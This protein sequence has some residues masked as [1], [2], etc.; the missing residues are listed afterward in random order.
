MINTRVSINCDYDQDSK[1]I[2]KK[3]QNSKL[4]QAN[5]SPC[6]Y[7]ISPHQ[8]V[9]FQIPTQN[10]QEIESSSS[11]DSF[12]SDYEK[13]ELDNQS[14]VTFGE[15]SSSKNYL[16]YGLHKNLNS[17]PASPSDISHEFLPLKYKNDENY[18]IKLFKFLRKPQN[19]NCKTDSCKFAQYFNF[20]RYCNGNLT[21]FDNKYNLVKSKKIISCKKIY[22]SQHPF[23]DTS[24]KEN[25][26][27]FY[28]DNDIGFN[29]KWQRP[30]HKAEMDDD[31]NTDDDQLRYA[32]KH[33]LQELKEGLRSFA[34]N[35]Y[36]TR[37]YK[38]YHYKNITL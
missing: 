37:N 19:S 30:I 5:I 9:S 29:S 14:P 10:K 1:T 26:F 36:N 16:Y 17:N 31:V 20:N 6:N 32:G 2:L 24:N 25:Y 15:I 7:K 23:Y 35:K 18:K 8:I 4:I 3:V 28:V 34:R 21:T 27:N 22:K 13:E 11:E 38:K 12:S 33:C